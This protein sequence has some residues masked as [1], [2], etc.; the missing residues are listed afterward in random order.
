MKPADITKHINQ[1]GRRARPQIY[2][3]KVDLRQLI[4]TTRMR[5]RRWLNI[6]TLPGTNITGVTGLSCLTLLMQ[7]VAFERENKRLGLHVCV[8]SEFGD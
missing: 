6:K 7:L 3:E 2:K 8:C 4:Q 5:M 1:I